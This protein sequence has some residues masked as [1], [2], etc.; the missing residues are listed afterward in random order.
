MHYIIKNNFQKHPDHEFDASKVKE[1][2]FRCYAC[3]E[4]FYDYGSLENHFIQKHHEENLDQEKVYLGNTGVTVP[5]LKKRGRNRIFHEE[6]IS[7]NSTLKKIEVMDVE[8]KAEDD[9]NDQE[10]AQKIK[11][12]HCMFC[13]RVFRHKHNIN[14]H[15]KEV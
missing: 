5:M 7:K 9:K 3:P 13:S 2:E 8:I 15:C 11:A 6:T 1:I 4:G 14:A 12:F 10:T